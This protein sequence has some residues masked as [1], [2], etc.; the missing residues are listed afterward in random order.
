MPPMISNT[1]GAGWPVLPGAAC[2][3]DSS[4]T[5]AGRDAMT[6]AVKEFCAGERRR[7]ARSQT[8]IM[9]LTNPQICLTPGDQR[10]T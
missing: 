6:S 1:T 4:D 9:M 10:A 5:W 2:N 8:T 7:T 3:Q